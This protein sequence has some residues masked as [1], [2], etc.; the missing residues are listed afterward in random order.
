MQKQLTHLTDKSS[1]KKVGPIPVSTSS[2]LNCPPTCPYN[3]NGCYADGGP[4]AIHWR[5]VTEGERGLSWDEFLRKV[6]AFP[7]GQLWRHN[8]AGDLLDINTQAGI[9]QLAELAVSSRHAKGF[10]YTHHPIKGLAAAEAIRFAKDYK[11]TVNMSCETEAQADYH[12]SKGRFAVL[13]VPQSENR[14]LYVTDGGNR[15][16]LCP[17]QTNPTVTC[18]TCQLCY[19]RDP[20][21]IIAFR[22]HGTGVKKATSALANSQ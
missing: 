17:Q 12:I 1:N 9:N 15:V 3:G 10:T 22:L 21:Q 7:N 11:F 13:T 14:K 20:K 6:E 19:K 4:L 16:M 5:K 2:R 8:Q 18:A